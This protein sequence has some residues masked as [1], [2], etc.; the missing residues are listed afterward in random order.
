VVIKYQEYL[1]HS[2]LQDY[3]KCFWILE[4]E[5][6]PENP[7]EEVTPDACIEL[8]FN[9]GARYVLQPD[10]MTER[11]MPE[12]FLIGMQKKPLLFRSSG[13]V[14]I[15]ATR[16]YAWGA[17]P[18]VATQAQT[19]NNLAIELGSEWHD[20]AEK[21]EPKVQSDDYEDAVACVEDFLISRL[22]TAAFD[23]KEIQIA[24]KLLYHQKGRFRVAE[25]ADYCNLS[26][27]QLQRRFQDV[28]GVPP[29]TLARTIRFDEIRNRLMF[30]TDTS[31]TDLAYE[32][33]Y[34]D[35]AH[36]SRDFKDFAGKTPGEF[37]AEM[38]ALQAV[39]HD[40]ENVVF[41]QSPSREST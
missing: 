23:L 40:N 41:L 16:F 9:F 28:A 17:L 3:V 2:S 30:D 24:A 26:T 8:I 35:Q 27:R 21:L 25:L 6:T 32:F 39:F 19:P 29:K 5:Y 20:L 14:R 12:A 11:E 13:T 7:N 34:S 1:P 37:A 38:R 33:G 36:F 15:V 18:F 10:R 4:K 31:L 22:L